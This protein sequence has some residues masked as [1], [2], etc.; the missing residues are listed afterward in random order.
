MQRR[1]KSPPVKEMKPMSAVEEA[2]NEPQYV[3]DRE[4]VR[5]RDAVFHLEPTNTLRHVWLHASRREGVA[6]FPTG[7]VHVR[8]PC[9]SSGGVNSDFFVS[10]VKSGSPH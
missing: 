3:V 7:Y 9:L 2:N 5:A 10:G 6:V 1:S 8:K 4:K